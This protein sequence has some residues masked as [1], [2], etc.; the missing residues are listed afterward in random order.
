GLSRLHQRALD[1][2]PRRSRRGRLRRH[3]RNLDFN[4]QLRPQVAFHND[5][6]AIPVARANG[7][8]TAAVTPSG[9]LLGGQVAVMDLDGWTWEESTVKTAVGITFQFPSIGGG[10]G[11]GGGA[12]GAPAGPPRPYQELKRER[13]V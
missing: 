10:G 4:P 7:V 3:G 1:D 12:F 5:S 2:W 8:T 13:D 11:R 9:G 6:E